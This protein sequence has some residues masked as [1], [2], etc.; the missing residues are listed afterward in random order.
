MLQNRP[1]IV[2]PN[3]LPLPFL[4]G[5]SYEDEGC[6][7]LACHSVLRKSGCYSLSLMDNKSFPYS[8]PPCFMNK[9][10]LTVHH[11]C[12]FL[13]KIICF[14]PLK[15]NEIY[16]WARREIIR[17]EPWLICDIFVVCVT[18]CVQKIQLRLMPLVQSSLRASQYKY[19][20]IW[21]G[22]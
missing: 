15:S 5:H 13:I 14:K 22:M 2:N 20:I 4:Q 7:L 16:S 18:L 12:L 17:N 19:F 9:T 11:F 8:L 10:G 3:F 6:I 21:L 1:E